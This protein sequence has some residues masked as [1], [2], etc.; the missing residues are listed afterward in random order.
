MCLG[1][2]HLTFESEIVRN[3]FCRLK[4]RKKINALKNMSCVFFLLAKY[5]LLI[6]W[7]ITRQKKTINKHQSVMIKK[8][9]SPCTIHI[10]TREFPLQNDDSARVPTRLPRGDHLVWR[11]AN[12]KI[13]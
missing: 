4:V 7:Q 10:Y 2:N 3:K 6:V 9:K 1:E 5:S 11:S 8:K 13:K 12:E